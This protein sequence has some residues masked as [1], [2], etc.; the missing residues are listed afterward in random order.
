MG[1]QGCL[2]I[3]M[4]SSDRTIRLKIDKNQRPKKP[5][6]MREQVVQALKAPFP[7]KCVASSY[8]VILRNGR[9]LS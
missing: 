5:T 4:G 6:L 9:N 2:F 1:N 8:T 3:G 7:K